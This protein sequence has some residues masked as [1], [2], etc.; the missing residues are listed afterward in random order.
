MRGPE[1]VP[2]AA[3]AE[4]GVPGQV[5]EVGDRAVGVAARVRGLAAAVRLDPLAD[6]ALGVGGAARLQVP[7]LRHVPVGH[8]AVAIRCAP[9]TPAKPTSITLRCAS[10]FSPTET[11]EEDAGRGE[12]LH[13]PDGVD[14]RGGRSRRAIQTQR[15]QVDER[16]VGERRAPEDLALVE[17][18]ER[19]R[20][21][22]QREQ[23]EVASEIGRRRSAR[24]RRKT[25]QKPS[26][27]QTP[28]IVLPPK[29]PASPAPS[30][31][32][33][34]APSSLAD[35]ARPVVDLAEHDLARLARPRLDH[36]LVG[37]RP[38][39]HLRLRIRRVAVEPVRDLVLA[40]EDPH[41]LLLGQPRGPRPGRTGS[42]RD[43]RPRRRRARSARPP[44]PARRARAPRA[45]PP[46][47][48]AASEGPELVPHEVPRGDEHDR[49][50]LR[51]HLADLQRVDEQV[52]DHE[53]GRERDRRD[54][55]EAKPLVGDVAALA[56]ERPEPV[57]GVVARDGDE[58]GAGRGEQ[59]VDAAGLEQE[60]VDRQ[61]DDVAAGADE[62]EA[63]QLSQFSLRR[64]RPACERAQPRRRERWSAASPREPSSAGR[65]AE[66]RARRPPRSGPRRA[67]GRSRATGSE[68]GRS[69]ARAGRAA[70][71][72]SRSRSPG[73][74][75]QSRRAKP[76]RA[77]AAEDLEPEDPR[78]VGVEQHARPRRDGSRGRARGGAAAWMPSPP[79]RGRSTRAA[80]R[81]TL[82]SRAGER[83]GREPHG[84]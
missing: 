29:A 30:S 17:H 19:D 28:L 80:G 16:R 12:Q 46:G 1:L 41:R 25:A 73:A 36:P 63:D 6:L 22:E 45:R 2:L 4:D 7:L 21:G 42:R 23:V 40:E 10:T 34:A 62:A 24:P 78:L 76:V 14:A 67:R 37:R 13:R 49:D 20:E 35:L 59:V 60:R 68:R 66:S 61:V 15:E 18:A 27:S 31:R 72:C 38:V 57:P 8:L 33:P 75:A 32:R 70:S 52:Q 79:A 26:Q 48:G 50:R 81:R 5:G 65:R 9:T 3:P 64:R 54:D 56:T 55:E 39:L 74:R 47:P 11:G 82:P 44:P 51:E 53:V 43:G 58:E 84:A 77:V 83:T 69:R 71:A